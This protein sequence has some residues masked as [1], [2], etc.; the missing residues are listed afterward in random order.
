MS[1]KDPYSPFQQYGH[2]VTGYLF[3][4]WGS[5]AFPVQVPFH[6]VGDS[7]PVEGTMDYHPWLNAT[8]DAVRV[9]EVEIMYKGLFR[10]YTAFWINQG[11]RPPSQ[12]MDHPTNIW[13]NRAVRCL[14]E[15]WKG[16][17]LVLRRAGARPSFVDT[18]DEHDENCAVQTVLR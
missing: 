10:Y 4:T 15:P 7:E 5:R 12:K 9:V 3:P 16:N 17:I 14:H 1:F 8:P 11:P 6:R 2:L 13:V 18:V